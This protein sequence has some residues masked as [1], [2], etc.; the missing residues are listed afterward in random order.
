MNDLLEFLLEADDESEDKKEEKEEKKEEEKKEEDDK[1]DDDTSS[2][3]EYNDLLD[4]DD[5][6]GDDDLGSDDDFGS[7]DDLGSDDDEYNDLI[8]DDDLSTD[9]PMDAGE[10]VADSFEGIA[11]I[12]YL[13]TVIS[14]NMK[15]IHLHAAGDK[16]KSIHSDAE[17]YY[18]HFSDLA[19][20]FFELAK[21]SPTVKVDNPTRAKEH[22]EDIDVETEEQYE[23]ETAVNRFK[24]NFTKAIEKL[25]EVRETVDRT[26]I[27]ST[28]DEELAYLNKKANYILA[29]QQLGGGGSTDVAIVAATTECVNYNDLF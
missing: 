7:D 13:Y 29:R 14:N 1:K 4:G 22:V 9:A 20:K 18:Y 24:F 27:Q 25:K 23:F 5:D 11:K 21:E 26:D 10:P 12:G 17:N 8:A 28:I 6:L 15:H 3:D 2:D 16:F 19:D